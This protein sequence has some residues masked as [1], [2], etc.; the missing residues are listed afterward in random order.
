MR[1]SVNQKHAIACE[2]SGLQEIYSRYDGEEQ[3][4]SRKEQN[5]KKDLYDLV[6]YTKWIT[7]ETG[8]LHESGRGPTHSALSVFNGQLRVIYLTVELCSSLSNS[9][10]RL[11]V[12]GKQH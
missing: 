1:A 7:T 3:R 2:V 5:Y 12:Q 9:S 4:F 6:E 10:Q 8:I 11:S